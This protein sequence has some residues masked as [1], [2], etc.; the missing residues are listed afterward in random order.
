[1]PERTFTKT[2]TLKVMKAYADKVGIKYP[3][4]IK[5]QDMYVLMD[6]KG[7]MTKGIGASS[8]ETVSTARLKLKGKTDAEKARAKLDI[9]RRKLRDDI[10]GT[11]SGGRRGGADA[12]GKQ[13]FP[14]YNNTKIGFYNVPGLKAKLMGKA[15]GEFKIVLPDGKE[16]P[17]AKSW[18]PVWSLV[19][20]Q[21]YGA[22]NKMTWL[23][24]YG[25]PP[26]SGGKIPKEDKETGF[27][28]VK[29]KGAEVLDR[30]GKAKVTKAEFDKARREL[31]RMAY[32]PK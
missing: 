17:M 23:K 18:R 3:K 12:F 2:T 27:N 26:G 9:A 15:V 31:A 24:K 13:N 22:R 7:M 1:M 32:R 10:T 5:K 16:I 19:E 20:A 28:S 21:T 8:S 14:K 11:G 4:G 30:T 6:K 25:P 29:K